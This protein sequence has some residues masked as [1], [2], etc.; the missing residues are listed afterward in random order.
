MT[1]KYTT[2][3]RKLTHFDIVMSKIRDAIIKE[4]SIPVEI[5]T[6]I[7]PVDNT[8]MVKIVANGL[9]N[10]W[11]EKFDITNS[12]HDERISNL[13]ELLANMFQEYIPECD[14]DCCSHVNYDQIIDDLC[15]RAAILSYNYTGNLTAADVEA[16]LNK[17]K[18][19]IESMRMKKPKWGPSGSSDDEYNRVYMKNGKYTSNRVHYSGER[20]GEE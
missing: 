8:I 14:N 19:K 9:E 3:K 11:G 5:T 13:S 18:E 16:F 1:N 20:Y 6:E 17:E 2:T 10:N 12:A 15:A 4:S 7:N